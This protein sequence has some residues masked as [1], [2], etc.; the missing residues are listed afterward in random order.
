DAEPERYPPYYQRNFHWQ[1]DGYLSRRSAAIY[2]L[3]VEWLFLGTADIMR[4][5]IIPPI[6]RFVAERG[7][8]RARLCDVGCGTGRTLAQIA[9]AHPKLRLFGIDISP[10]YLTAARELLADQPDA[11]FLVENAETLP[12]QDDTF[13]IVTS[14]FVFHELPKDAR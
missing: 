12:L 5:Q 10:Y 7:D 4:R 6:T 14:V 8:P 3:G 2:D 13:D 11:S 1:T 9:A